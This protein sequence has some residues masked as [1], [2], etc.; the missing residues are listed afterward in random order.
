M[1]LFYALEYNRIVQIKQ[2]FFV[3]T[4]SVDCCGIGLYT[5]KMTFQFGNI[6]KTHNFSNNLVIVLHLNPLEKKEELLPFP[7]TAG[8][9]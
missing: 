6:N 8:S 5:Q 2:F 9:N 1:V 3:L 4:T 7:G